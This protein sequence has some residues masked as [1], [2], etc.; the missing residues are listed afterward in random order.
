MYAV[1]MFLVIDGIAF[2]FYSTQITKLIP[3]DVQKDM[4]NKIAGITMIILGTGASIGS[5]VVGLVAD[6]LGGL[7]AGRIG[8][9]LFVL[10]CGVFMA[11]Y[12]WHQLWLTFIAGF[13]WGFSLFYI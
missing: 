13:I 9:G 4:I 5:I 12:S 2:G 3:P 7:M 10:N 1:L 8:L 11:A 6:K